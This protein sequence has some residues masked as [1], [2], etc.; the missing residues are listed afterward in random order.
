MMAVSCDLGEEG[1]C[2]L[3][4]VVEILDDFLSMV[5]RGVNCADF[6]PAGIAEDGERSK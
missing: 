2:V 3:V 6:F 5:V 1:G 4:V